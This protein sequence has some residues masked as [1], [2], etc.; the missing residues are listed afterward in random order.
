MDNQCDRC[1]AQLPLLNTTNLPESWRECYYNV[2]TSFHIVLGTNN[3]WPDGDTDWDPEDEFDLCPTC[4]QQFLAFWNIFYNDKARALFREVR[5]P[6]PGPLNEQ[7]VQQIIDD[8]KSM[9]REELVA[10]YIE[11]RRLGAIS[12]PTEQ[13]SPIERERRTR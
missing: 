2:V 11:L 10:R 9:T 3:I 1:G 5:E 12:T 6:Q 13:E 4:Q 8:V 7:R